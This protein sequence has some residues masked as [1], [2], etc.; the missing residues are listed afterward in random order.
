M[1]R[2]ELRNKVDLAL[3]SDFYGGLL[4]E[5]QR[6]VLSL[7]CE[8]DYSLGEISEEAGISRQ[9]VPEGHEGASSLPLPPIYRLSQ[10]RRYKA[11]PGQTKGRCGA[12]VYLFPAAILPGS[13]RIA[14]TIPSP[15]PG[16][17]G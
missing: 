17:S 8:E 5:K 11:I 13:L 9:A 7:Y 3:L 6:R 10:G 15:L 4:T 2:E 16:L 12:A 14:G 1:S